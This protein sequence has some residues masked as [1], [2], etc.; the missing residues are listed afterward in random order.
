MLLVCGNGA[1][2]ADVRAASGEEERY[3]HTDLNG[4][5]ANLDAARKVVDLMRPLLTKS[6]AQLLPEI[7]SAI[8]A[9]DAELSGLKVDGR[10]ASYDSVTADQRK[11]IADK[12]KALA[13][14]LDGIDPA[15]GL[16]GLK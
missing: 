3:S 11:Q 12:A 1:L 9:L 2:Q 13:V 15:L 7:D 8:S 5:A 4:F 6:A 14:A 10:Y 16:S